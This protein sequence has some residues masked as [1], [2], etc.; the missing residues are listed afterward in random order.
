MEKEEELIE[1]KLQKKSIEEYLEA[2]LLMQRT[3]AGLRDKG[4]KN[5]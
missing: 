5:Y 2:E 4:H 3:M 1:A